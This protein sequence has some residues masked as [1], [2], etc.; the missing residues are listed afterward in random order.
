MI[1]PFPRVWPAIGW[2]SIMLVII[3]DKDL[4]LHRM[5]KIESIEVIRIYPVLD[6]KQIGFRV[7]FYLSFLAYSFYVVSLSY[8]IGTILVKKQK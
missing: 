3:E 2:T 7:P 6:P 5:L 1:N 8:Y 4:T